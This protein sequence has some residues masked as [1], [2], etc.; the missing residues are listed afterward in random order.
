VA[1]FVH[2]PTSFLP[3]EDQGVLATQA[4]LPAGATQERT[5]KVLDIITDHYLHDEKSNV[6]NVLTVNGYG[7]AGRGQNVG[8]A[9]VGIAFV[10]LKDWSERPGDDN[11]VTAIVQRA[12]ATFSKIID[13]TVVAFNL[14]P[15]I[16]LGNATGFDFELIDRGNLGHEKL[17]EA[18]NQLLALAA[19]HPDVLMAVRANGMEDTP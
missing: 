16:A 1:M 6:A 10:G 17:L 3:E 5:Q 19:Q 2:L 18:R 11:K 14:P 9:F 13:G 4:I 7:F 15:I 8:I 12:N